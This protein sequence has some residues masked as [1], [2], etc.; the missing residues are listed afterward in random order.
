MFF[1]VVKSRKWPFG[2]SASDQPRL[3]FF[4]FRFFFCIIYHVGWEQ[5]LIVAVEALL[6]S[7][8]VEMAEESADN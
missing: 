2:V 5:S 3:F 7:L 4:P 8:C 1:L 6:I